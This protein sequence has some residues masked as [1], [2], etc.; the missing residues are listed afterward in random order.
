MM[1]GGYLLRI[2]TVDARARALG[3]AV[4]GVRGL[5]M[6]R[7]VFMTLFFVFLT[8]YA[9]VYATC[10]GGGGVCVVGGGGARDERE[11]GYPERTTGMGHYACVE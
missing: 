5:T 6:M 2:F 10:E 8:V 9:D 7:V 1:G 11:R 3:A 4:V